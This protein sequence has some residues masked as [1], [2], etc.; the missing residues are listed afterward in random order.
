MLVKHIFQYIFILIYIPPSCQL[1]LSKTRQTLNIYTN[2][3]IHTHIFLHHVST[4]IP[5]YIHIHIFLYD[6][7]CFVYSTRF[8]AAAYSI[9]N[10]HQKCT[11]IY[12][13]IYSCIYIS[14]FQDKIPPK[15]KKKKSFFQLRFSVATLFRFVARFAHVRI[16]DSSLT[17]FA[18]TGIQRD[19]FGGIL[20]GYPHSHRLCQD[21]L[22]RSLA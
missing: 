20:S 19:F 13:H 11:K 16:E 18:L 21:G 1:N 22:N 17:R 6:L 7:S 14:W 8:S 3:Y 2:I 5:I 12:I 9:F 15:K 4:Y 10:P